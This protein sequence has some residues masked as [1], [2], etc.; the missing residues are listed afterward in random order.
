MCLIV[1]ISS[2]SIKIVSNFVYYYNEYGNGKLATC[3]IDEGHT[4]FASGGIQAFEA[5]HSSHTDIV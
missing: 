5:E 1:L 2:T 4:S 3:T